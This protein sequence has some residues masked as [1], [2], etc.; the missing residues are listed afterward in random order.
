M[1]LQ[2]ISNYKFTLHEEDHK[3]RNR[4]FYGF[5]DEKY[6]GGIKDSP[7]KSKSLIKNGN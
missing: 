6:E 5:P 4:L 2:I 7:W 3:N 1:Y